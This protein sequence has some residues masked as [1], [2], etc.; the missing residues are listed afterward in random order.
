MQTFCPYTSGFCAGFID[1]P[2]KKTYNII[3]EYF[4]RKRPRC[5]MGP[6][7]YLYHFSKGRTHGIAAQKVM[8]EKN[9]K[10]ATIRDVAKAAGVS[11]STVSRVL[12]NNGYVGEDARR[13][14]EEAVEALHYSPSAIAVCLSKCRSRMIGVIVPQIFAPFFSQMYYIADR[15]MERYGYRLL[16][17]NSDESLKRE[18][19]LI[20]DLLSYKIAAL[21]IVPVDGDEGSNKEYLDHI[22]ST[23]TPVVC[24]DREIEGIQCDGV[25]I[26]NYTACYEI[27]KDVLA[28]GYRNIAYMAD[29]PIYR[30]GRDRLRGFW[31]ACK[32]FGVTVPQENIFL[33][34]IEDTEPLNAFLHDIACRDDPPKAI[35]NFVRGWDYTMLQA[36]HSAG[37]RVPEDVYLTGLDDDDTLPN[38]GYSMQYSLSI[39]D[40]VKAVAELLIKRAESAEE[41]VPE[42]ERRI[43]TTHMKPVFERKVTLPKP[44]AMPTETDK[45]EK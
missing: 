40:F 31:D 45:K 11:Q 28:R 24:V 13:R 39:N 36:L 30:P 41:T 4:S 23:G 2:F 27:T 7:T 35:I 38:F 12:N 26:D 10:K 1:N 25:Y 33:A 17:C 6:H 18:K 14:V 19:E 16:L 20:D 43:F 15:I 37:L 9:M 34:P 8:E 44:D 5:G 22:R 3:L 21:L 29:P 42:P 32:E